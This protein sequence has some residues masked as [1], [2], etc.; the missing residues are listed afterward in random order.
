MVKKKDADTIIIEKSASIKNAIIITNDKYL[1]RQIVSFGCKYLSPNEFYDL[2]ISKNK[3]NSKSNELNAKKTG[4]VTEQ[5]K[6]W[7]KKEMFKE[8][9]KKRK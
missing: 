4:I 2:I 1:R 6:N 9:N 3:K 7:W 8:L 5:E